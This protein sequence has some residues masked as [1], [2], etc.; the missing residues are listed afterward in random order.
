[1]HDAYSHRWQ[2]FHRER[3]A[4]GRQRAHW[5]CLRCGTHLVCRATEYVRSEPGGGATMNGRPLDC[6]RI[7]PCRPGR[8]TPQESRRHAWTTYATGHDTRAHWTCQQCGLEAETAISA[9]SPSSDH[10]APY[11]RRS[12]TEPWER[13]RGRI[14]P[15]EADR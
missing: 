12:P 9:T 14:G 3:L 5:T 13:Y 6:G 15:C 10:G 2:L 7:P 11:R 4:D 8:T 1:M